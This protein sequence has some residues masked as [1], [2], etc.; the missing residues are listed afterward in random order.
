MMQIEITAF[1]NAIAC[2]A[3]PTLSALAGTAL[4]VKDDN[5]VRFLKVNDEND[6]Q[7]IF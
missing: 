4:M 2:A 7:N 1:R 3:F 6:L 5:L